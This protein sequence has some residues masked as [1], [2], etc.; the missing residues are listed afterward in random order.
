MYGGIH[1]AL[2]AF[3][4][5]TLLAA[6]RMD[7]DDALEVVQTGRCPAAPGATAAATGRQ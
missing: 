6:G 7:P 5:D 3:M 1:K 2:R 4:A